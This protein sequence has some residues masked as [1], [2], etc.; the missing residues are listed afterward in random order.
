MFYVD[1]LE[2]PSRPVGTKFVEKYPGD[3]GTMWYKYRI[4]GW[5]HLTDG[6]Y[7]KKCRFWKN[8]KLRVEATRYL[9]SLPPAP[10][11]HRLK[12]SVYR[13]IVCPKTLEQLVIV[14]RAYVENPDA[15]RK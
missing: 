13:K 9:R 5:F 1:A 8:C 4:V 12:V 2:K 15:A 11:P 14:N 6:C 10:D 3:S 7:G